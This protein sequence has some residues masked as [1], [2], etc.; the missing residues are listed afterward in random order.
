[1]SPTMS[2]P[3]LPIQLLLCLTLLL[4][5]TAS[6]TCDITGVSQTEDERA[7]P[8][9]FGRVNLT[10]LTLQP[11][12]SLLASTVVPPTHYTW[13]GAHADSVLWKCDK[14]DFIGGE[15]YFLMSTNGDSRFGGHHDIGRADGLSDIYATWFQHVGLRLSMDGVVFSRYWRKVPIKPG[16]YREVR[17]NGRDR[18]HIRLGDIPPVHAELYRLTQL[19]PRGGRGGSSYCAGYLD[20]E[21]RGASEPTAT[22]TLYAC[23]YPNAYIQLHGPGLEGRQD[24]EGDDHNTHYKSWYADNG[25]AWRLY[26]AVT[27]SRTPTCA[28][29]SATPEV[30]FATTHVGQLQAGVEVPAGF[31]IVVDCDNAAKPGI[32][33]HQ[34]AIG[35]QVSSGA[36]AAAQQLGL[37][38]GQRGVEYLV[39][40]QYGDDPR[41]A[42]GVGIKLYGPDGNPHLFVGHPGTVGQ[43]HPRGAQA[44]WYP[45]NQG[46]QLV[47]DSANGKRLQLNFSASLKRLP[48]QE[49]T[50]GKIHATA[51][52]LVKVQ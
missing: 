29:H 35:L 50:P 12:G 39:S 8:I 41:L 17:E 2:P 4:A 22:G 15:V 7:A 23:P 34:T 27:L 6:A 51:H 24:E 18:I 16:Q 48:G 46:A 45:V 43:G 1:M 25:F 52:I 9:P 42:Q 11:Y 13:G 3:K 32:N 5:Q 19:P 30:R 37:V 10:H 28:V 31:S 26:H 40:D 38:N 33:D 36:F 20:Q 49:V 44:G 14:A 21:G 47:D